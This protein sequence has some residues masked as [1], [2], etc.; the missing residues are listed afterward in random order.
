MVSCHLFR[1]GR[2]DRWYRQAIPLADDRFA[3]HLAT[4]AD[5]D[6]HDLDDPTTNRERTR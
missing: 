5:T 2:W 1:A 3:D 4:L 6:H